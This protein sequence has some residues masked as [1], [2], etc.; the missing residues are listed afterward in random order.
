M[1]NINLLYTAVTR[2]KK[3]CILISEEY[4]IKKIIEEKIIIKRKSNLSKFCKKSQL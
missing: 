4:P 3:K 2:A 1:N